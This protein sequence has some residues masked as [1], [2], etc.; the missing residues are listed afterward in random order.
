MHING[1]KQFQK[2]DMV[3]LLPARI[4]SIPS[5]I[6]SL[7]LLLRRC[8]EH[9]RRWFLRLRFL[10]LE[11]PIILEESERF[12]L[13]FE[14]NGIVFRN[15]QISNTKRDKETYIVQDSTSAW[16]QPVPNC[17]NWF[18]PNEYTAPSA[19]AQIV[20]HRPAATSSIRIPN[21]DDTHVG[22]SSS[23]VLPWPHLRE[24]KNKSIT[25]DV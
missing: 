19:E 11:P 5:R 7:H 8:D 2:L 6:L 9:R 15:N 21:K 23:S 13:G 10:N 16:S 22:L 4:C 25:S 20:C 18:P 3:C 17:P 14:F 1:T 24:Q 12:K